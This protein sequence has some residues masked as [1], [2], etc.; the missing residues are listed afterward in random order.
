MGRTDRG[1]STDA[2]EGGGGGRWVYIDGETGCIGRRV[3]EGDVKHS[4]WVSQ[5]DEGGK[6]TMSGW[7]LCYIVHCPSVSLLSLSSSLFLP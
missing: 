4:K 2:L 1:L 7:G 6:T 5:A 3:G